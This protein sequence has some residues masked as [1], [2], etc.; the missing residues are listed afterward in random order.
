MPK[1]K[2]GRPPGALNKK[3]VITPNESCVAKQTRGQTKIDD[4]RTIP[5]TTPPTISQQ[6]SKS[7]ARSSMPPKVSNKLILKRI[8]RPRTSQSIGNPSETDTDSE[9]P[10][11]DPRTSTLREQD[12][13]DLS[14]E[15]QI[16]VRQEASSDAESK[17]SLEQEPLDSEIE[18]KLTSATTSFD[19]PLE[20]DVFE[21]ELN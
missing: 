19:E 9:A 21:P 10:R 4:L 14:A 12:T 11:Y 6:R 15:S 18:L 5:K 7:G 17:S 3:Y 2:I 1:P 13:E 8:V 16:R 20:D